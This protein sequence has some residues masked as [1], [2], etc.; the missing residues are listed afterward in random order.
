MGSDAYL[1]AVRSRRSYYELE[2]RSTIPDAKIQE[3]VEETLRHTPSTFNSQ[4]TRLV[5]LLGAEH[6]RLWNDIVKPAVKAIMPAEG[7]PATEAKL[8]GF[9]QSYGTVLLYEDPK[10]VSALQAQYAIFA[11]KFPQWSEHTNAMHAHVLWTALEQEGLGASLQHYNP[12]IDEGI[13]KQWK[14]PE[15]WQLKAQLVF[16]KPTGQPLEKTFM[17]ME[18]RLKVFGAK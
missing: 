12:L 6:A 5:L 18:E 8:T 11:D 10:V 4:S 3:I 7:W 14:I 13:C 15:D 1:A 9:Q 2:A 17:P 16:G